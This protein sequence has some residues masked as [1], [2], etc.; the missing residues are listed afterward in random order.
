MTALP[1]SRRTHSTNLGPLYKKL[2]GAP[3]P[4]AV[5][6]KK[7]DTLSAIA[8]R[9]KCTVGELVKANPQL[10]NANHLRPGQ[11]IVVPYKGKKYDPTQVCRPPKLEGRIGRAGAGLEG[12]A[13]AGAGLEGRAGAGAGLEGK[14]QPRMIDLVGTGAPVK[15]PWLF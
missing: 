3:I 8:K 5:T 4:G 6:V 2:K 12:R 14:K 1:I 15:L 9:C 7:G 11:Q 13:G 10:K